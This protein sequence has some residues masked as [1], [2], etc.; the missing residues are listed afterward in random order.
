ME[1]RLL[2]DFCISSCHYI[3]FFSKRGKRLP[4]LTLWAM[5][6]SRYA[7]T[8]FELGVGSS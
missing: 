4:L 1:K 3:Y 5:Q 7:K 2:N 6:P 8:Q